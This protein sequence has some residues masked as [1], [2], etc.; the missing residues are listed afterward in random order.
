MA[1][2]MPDFFSIP[3][4]LD[5]EEASADKHELFRGR[6]FARAGGSANHDDVIVSL[7][8]I[9]RNAL[10]D[11]APCRFV[12]ENRKLLVRSEGSAYR[13]DGAIACPPNDLNPQQ[14]TYDNPTVVFEVLSPG[15]ADFDRREKA[16]DYKTIPSLQDYV[17][18][19]SERPRIEVFSRLSD[20]RWAQSVY[21][22]GAIARLPSVGIDLPLDELYENVAFRDAPPI[23]D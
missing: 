2:A 11:R 22:A 23:R 14:G 3:E 7:T 10:R 15:T 16:D 17:L 9:C 8:G 19:E 4:F 6:I 20:G 1:S 18:I 5:F 12:G 21:V 13:P